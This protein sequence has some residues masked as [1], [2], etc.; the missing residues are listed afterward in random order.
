MASVSSAIFSALQFSEAESALR[1]WWDNIED[2][3]VYIILILAVVISPTSVPLGQPLECTKCDH[4]ICYPMY[5]EDPSDD[6]PNFDSY[7]VRKY[8][9]HQL[10][11]FV[12]YFP[13]VLLSIA[14]VLVVIDRPFVSHLF[15]SGNIDEVYKILVRRD[16]ISLTSRVNDRIKI[17]SL[18]SSITS[19][20]HISYL[21]RTLFSILAAI[22]A[23]TLVSLTIIDLV[24]LRTVPGIIHCEVHNPRM[25]TPSFHY[26]C[27]GLHIDLYLAVSSISIILLT[28]YLLLNMYN[29]IWI[30]NPHI[31]KLRRIL[32]KFSETN[33]A[34]GGDIEE[35]YFN[36]KNIQL[37][38][39][40]LVSSS[41]LCFPLQTLTTVD[42]EFH[43]A[44]TPEITEADINENGVRVSM[45]IK[46]RP[47]LKSINEENGVKLSFLLEESDDDGVVR[48]QPFSP[49]NRIGAD[50]DTHVAEMSGRKEYGETKLTVKTLVNGKTIAITLA[51]CNEAYYSVAE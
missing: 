12:V 11:T 40:L 22:S 32:T 39:C 41:G 37:L 17:R 9:H 42:N 8:C 25:S 30:L 45:T 14:A 15:K 1:P 3:S 6:D 27:S 16:E 28:F 51:E 18:L 43:S 13:I 26:G 35:F 34:K 7:F 49:S 31:G 19:S 46:P 10:P 36:N 2:Y 5:D 33:F 20:Y 48:V 24:G 21:I 4:Y 44:C 23:L 38:L 47:V 29:F 50:A